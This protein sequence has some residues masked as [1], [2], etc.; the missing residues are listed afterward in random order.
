MKKIHK[1]CSMKNYWFR[2]KG[3]IIQIEECLDIESYLGLSKKEWILV[4]N[5]CG[6]KL[7]KKNQHKTAKGWCKYCYDG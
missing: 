2:R 4:C 6:N 3:A 5:A 7:N 1:D